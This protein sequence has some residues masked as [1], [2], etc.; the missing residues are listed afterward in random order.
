[1]QCSCARPCRA[2]SSTGSS[3]PGWLT[4]GAV[5]SRRWSR[6]TSSAACPSSGGRVRSPTT[7]ASR[8]S[9]RLSAWCPAVGPRGCTSTSSSSTCPPRPRWRCVRVTVPDSWAVAMD[10]MVEG[11]GMDTAFAAPF[12]ETSLSAIPAEHSLTIHLLDDGVP[13]GGGTVA[14]T[15]RRGGPLQHRRARVGARARCRA[16]RHPRAAPPGPCRGMSGAM[17]HASE[18]GFPV[19]AAIGFE[20]VGRVHMRVWVPP[21]AS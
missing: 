6:S 19:Y 11:F 5:G 20:E 15:R 9:L 17:L 13:V 1:M 21:D 12:A 8:T 14:F 4:I 16:S 10:T 18:M 2:P 7:T 3:L